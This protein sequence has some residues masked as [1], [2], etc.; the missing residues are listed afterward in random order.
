SLELPNYVDWTNGRLLEVQAA[1]AQ[2]G[3]SIAPESLLTYQEVTRHVESLGPLLLSNTVQV[4]TGVANVL[5]QVFII[6]LL[7]YYF[8]LD[9]HRISAALL[10]ALPS[11]YRD[12]ARYF[13]VSVHR[14]FAGFIR[15]QLAQ[16]ALYGM[17]TAAVM[18]LV[19]L[20]LVLLSAVLAGAFMLL[21]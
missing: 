19:G 1:L 11:T 5:F 9:G 20:Q 8:T 13:F 3:V 14:A 4:A 2:Q 12:D 7:S 21:P 6:L 18:Q 10:M 17:G 15:G 16:A